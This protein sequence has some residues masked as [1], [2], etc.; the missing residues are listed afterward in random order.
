MKKKFIIPLIVLMLIATGTFIGWLI[1]DAY[2]DDT[3]GLIDLNAAAETN[4]D[5]VFDF[6]NKSDP[7]PDNM[8]GYI[9]N[10]E[11]DFDTSAEDLKSS[12][13]TVFEK[14]DA[15]MPNTVLIKYTDNNVK[16]LVDAAKENKIDV[17][18][19]IDEHML[20][21]DKIAV[22]SETYGVNIF[23][24]DLQNDN[25]I[26]KAEEI[27][28]ELNSQGIYIG[29]SVSESLTDD[30]KTSV[31][32][33]A[34][35]F[36]FVKIES[37]A[38]ENAEDFIKSWAAEGLTSSSKI[39]AILRND[40]VTANDPTEILK[41][42]KC[43]YNY[44][45]FSGC[46]MA[47]REKLSKDD[48]STTTKLYSYYEYFNNSGYTALS[49]NAFNVEKDYSLIT[50]GGNT[51]D[52]NYPVH[53]WC[54]A[55]QSWS[56]I[57]LNEEDGTFS[58]S[59]PLIYGAN[60]IVIKHKSAM[61]TYN[62]DRVTDIMIS[63]NATI[64]NGIVTFNVTAL[65][66]A[67]VYASVANLHTVQLSQGADIDTMYA[68]YT[69]TFELE[70]NLNHLTA[71][72]ISYATAYN[73][74]TDIVLCNKEKAI[75]PYD[76][77]SL[78]R[79]DFCLITEDYAETTSTASESD[80]SDPTCTPQLAGSYCKVIDYTVKVNNVIC[81]SD[82][83]MKFYMGQSRLIL[84]GYTMPA[85]NINLD[86]VS[87]T[88]GTTLT[89]SHNYP[90]FVK[91]LQEPQEYYTGYLSRIY[92]VEEFTA[93]YIDI[94]FM[95]TASCSQPMQFDLSASQ[96]FSSYEWYSNE[97][98]GFITLRLHLKNKG[99]FNG[100]S[101]RYDDDGKIVISF[102]NNTSS[103]Q[104][105]VI[106]LDP[107]HGGYGSP[108]TNYN[109][110]IYEKEITFAVANETAKILRENG[111]TV[112]MTRQGDDALFLSE[113][114]EMIRELNPDLCVSIHCDGVDSPSVYGTHT[115][116][117][118]SYSMP[119]ARSVHNQLVN[120]YRN[121][122]Y[123]DSSSAE[124]AKVDKGHKFYPY[125]IARVEECPCVLVEMGYMTNE[126]DARFLISEGG[127]KILA[128]AIAQGITDYIV[129]Y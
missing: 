89:L 17:I 124:Y 11:K 78:G 31:K 8:R 36:Y 82:T 39:Y 58:V 9:I 81:Q 19:H 24:A 118:K 114:V 94:L 4:A 104:G 129:N 60:K 13:L 32:N 49:V 20:K 70:E 101:Y 28:D 126:N 29:A 64:E 22:L 15:I 103:L 112:I 55:S 111:A 127:Q 113:R 100:Y 3:S 74:L 116:Y 52:I 102:K 105:S 27:R 2:S 93:E 117:F 88:D 59:V 80:A 98:N 33:A 90:A 6:L 107:G 21:S 86:A 30:V 87:F 45:G 108:G 14:V 77:H 99:S 85:N 106:M 46:V 62:I 53:V 69:G 65:K 68:V 72:Y 10:P 18:F 73:G 79:G 96:I 61:Y 119:L 43:L 110:E 34:L 26:K 67:S 7:L 25:H 91:I 84:G 97:Q 57:P 41:L 5:T 38:E 123:T 120:A 23:C 44:G 95:D 71:D 121:Y 125:M 16:Y 109:M 56:E 50:L 54:T 63:E 1:Y 48:N 83:G 12:A 115:F 37:H 75:T 40:K 66:N 76:D 51:T 122:Y 128:T 35:D 42:V 47:D 92:N